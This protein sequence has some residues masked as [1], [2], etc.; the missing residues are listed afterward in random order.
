MSAHVSLPLHSDLALIPWLRQLVTKK[1]ED[2][3]REQKVTPT[4]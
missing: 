2:V 4:S 1:L 3:P